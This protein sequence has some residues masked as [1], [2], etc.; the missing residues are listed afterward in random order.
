MSL[1]L[2]RHGHN[3]SSDSASGYITTLPTGY[4]SVNNVVTN[5]SGPETAFVFGYGPALTDKTYW[6]LNRNNPVSGNATD[7]Y[8]GLYAVDAAA[9]NYDVN[10]TATGTTHPNGFSWRTIGFVYNNGVLSTGHATWD[11]LAADEVLM[12]A[13]DATAEIVWIGSNGVWQGDPS[14]GTGGFDVSWA[15]ALGG[16]CVAIQCNQTG[17]AFEI[18]VTTGTLDYTIP[19]GFAALT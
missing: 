14:T 13:Y 15:T 17:V 16:L 7:S 2:A 10:L 19:T 3:Y 8:P 6:E 5:V 1:L 11:G 9:A 18:K 4:T 12:F